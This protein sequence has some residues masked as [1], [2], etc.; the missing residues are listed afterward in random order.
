MASEHLHEI[1][2]ILMKYIAEQVCWDVWA[3][4]VMKTHDVEKQTDT[5]WLPLYKV[6]MEKT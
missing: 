5:L 2:P 6:L 1:G 3:D 4:I